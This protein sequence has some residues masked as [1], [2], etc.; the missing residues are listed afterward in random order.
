MRKRPFLLVLRFAADDVL[1]GM[2][3][4]KRLFSQAK[5]ALALR[6][7][8]QVRTLVPEVSLEFLFAKERAN[9]GSLSLSQKKSRFPLG[10]GYQL[11]C[12]M[13]KF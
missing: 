13:T 6:K 5:R 11:Q 3:E 10:P 7:F 12:D 4:K 1:R 9:R 8:L 2:R